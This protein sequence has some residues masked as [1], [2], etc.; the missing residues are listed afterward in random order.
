M[1]ESA[2]IF[3]PGTTSVNGSTAAGAMFDAAFD[4]FDARGNVVLQDKPDVS[5]SAGLR[6]AGRRY[7]ADPSAD[8]RFE[9]WERSQISSEPRRSW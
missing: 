3:R 4:R 6:W 2:A 1:W 9:I 5:R 8:Y 7:V